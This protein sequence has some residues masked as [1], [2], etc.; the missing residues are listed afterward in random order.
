MQIIRTLLVY[1]FLI[2]TF[3]SCRKDIP[4]DVS[5]LEQEILEVHNLSRTYHFKK[6]VNEFIDQQSDNLLS[7]SDGKISRPTKEDRRKR[8]SNYFKTVD[9]E[10]WDDI[11]P[12]VIRFSNDFS[13]AYT[14]VN[15]EVVLTYLDE[16]N[17]RVRQ[18]TIFSW[19]SIYTKHD[20]VWKV[21]CVAST[22][23]PST[24]NIIN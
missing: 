6:M 12:P 1:V 10:K 21:D 15:K 4:V 17:N 13:M 24:S 5:A 19:V 11:E 3:Y 16:K 22:N 23:Q 18:T 20:G 7:I 14:A 2:S 9:F 8:V